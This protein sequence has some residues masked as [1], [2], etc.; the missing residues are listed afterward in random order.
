MI[1]IFQDEPLSLAQ[2][3]KV[4][5]GNPSYPSVYRW[6]V[7]GRNGVR[8]ET[9]VIGDKRYTTRAAIQSFFEAVT[10]SRDPA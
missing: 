2:A 1:N 9:I 3:T 10:A 8:L 7:K 6:A 5:P 4:I